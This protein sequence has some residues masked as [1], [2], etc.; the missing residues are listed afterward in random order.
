MRED[1]VFCVAVSLG[2]ISDKCIAFT[3]RARIGARWKVISAVFVFCMPNVYFRSL[4]RVLQITCLFPP[5][6]HRLSIIPQHARSLSAFLDFASPNILQ[7][8][9]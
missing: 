4:A 8:P 1:S 6:Q 7:H 3:H 9:I 2:L 5:F